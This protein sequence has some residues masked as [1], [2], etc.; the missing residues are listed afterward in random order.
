MVIDIL[1][2]GCGLYLSNYNKFTNI[3][4]NFLIKFSNLIVGMFI[5]Y[6]GTKLY[7]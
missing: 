4:T 5:F 1:R 3:D 2:V 7:L 6:K